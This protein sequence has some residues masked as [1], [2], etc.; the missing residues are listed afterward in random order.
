VNHRGCREVN[1]NNGGDI[2]VETRTVCR[3][4]FSLLNSKNA[5]TAGNA[6][7]PPLF[8][9]FANF[10]FYRVLPCFPVGEDIL[11]PMTKGEKDDRKLQESRAGVFR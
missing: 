5:C 2:P 1:S 9:A 4:F 7:R 10:T 11:Q 3:F 6:T 8:Q